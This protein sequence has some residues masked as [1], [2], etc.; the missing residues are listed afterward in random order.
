MKEIKLSNS[1]K[2]ALVDD[3]DYDIVNQYTWQIVDE[4]N[5]VG[6]SKYKLHRFIYELHSGEIPDGYFVDHCNRNPLLNIMNNL[7]LANA[8]QNAWNTSKRNNDSGFRGVS[9]Y[10]KKKYHNDGSIYYVKQW[11]VRIT[12]EKKTYTKYFP[13]TEEGKIQAA[14]WFDLKAKELFGKFCGELNFPDEK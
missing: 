3:C 7:R 11:R 1:D 6:N 12:K 10:K 4:Q 2:V 13:F 8:Y 9:R 14:K 5:H